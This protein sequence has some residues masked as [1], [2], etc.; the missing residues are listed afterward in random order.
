[1]FSIDI[2]T[3]VIPAELGNHAGII[4]AALYANEHI[5]LRQL[6]LKS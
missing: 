5:K 1:M 4:G 2:N 6:S 3:N